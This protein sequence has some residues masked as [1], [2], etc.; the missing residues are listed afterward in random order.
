MSAF[1]QLYLAS[2]K[3][4]V[5]DRMSL[6]WTLAFP[7]VFVVMFGVLFSFNGDS[8]FDVGLVVED[9]G[10]AGQQ[11]AGFLR[12]VP[13]FKLSEDSEDQEL[14]ALK[15]GDRRAVIVLP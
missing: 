10:Q 13:V 15:R 4:F 2:L 7:L 3:E 9:Q 1:I 11:V 6:F 5:R 14:A 8:Q 12:Q